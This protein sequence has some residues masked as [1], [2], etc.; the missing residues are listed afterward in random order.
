MIRYQMWLTASTLALILC[1]E[2]KILDNLTFNGEDLNNATK[3]N[4]VT[5]L[6]V[7]RTHDES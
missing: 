1:A 4:F 2:Y 3:S 7:H 6:I 5:E